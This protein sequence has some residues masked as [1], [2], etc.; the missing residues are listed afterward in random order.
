[1]KYSLVLCSL[2]EKPLSDIDYRNQASHTD[3]AGHPDGS[4]NSDKKRTDRGLKCMKMR[5]TSRH[6]LA[7]EY[8]SIRRAEE[9]QED[10]EE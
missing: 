1:M 9:E 3:A 8:V 5:V 6:R 4:K 10:D 7:M 2:Q